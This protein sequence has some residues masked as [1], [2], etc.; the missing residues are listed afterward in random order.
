MSKKCVGETGVSKIE[1]TAGKKKRTKGGRSQI[2]QKIR[3][4]PKIIITK[5][6]RAKK[7]YVT[8]VCDLAALEIDIKEAQ[9]YFVQIFCGTSRRG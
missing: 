5:I 2:K 3:L 6:P 9:R 8:R 4:W 7:K 1:G